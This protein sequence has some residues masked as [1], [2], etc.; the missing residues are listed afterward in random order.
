MRNLKVY[1]IYIYYR[2][3]CVICF[4]VNMLFILLIT[5][6]I[7][8]VTKIITA[9]LNKIISYSN[10]VP[11]LVWRIWC[12][13]SYD[14]LQLLTSMLFEQVFSLVVIEQLSF[15]ILVLLIIF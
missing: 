5:F 8:V 2:F 13:R 12:R 10:A 9:E 11:T 15:F 1:N 4:V 7:E 14:D 3:T 6:G